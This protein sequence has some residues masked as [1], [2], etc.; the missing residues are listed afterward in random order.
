MATGRTLAALGVIAALVV[1]VLV[2]GTGD[3]RRIWCDV[4]NPTLAGEDGSTPR[5]RW[6]PGPNWT[7]SVPG[8]YEFHGWPWSEDAPNFSP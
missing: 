6:T 3:A 4:A 5:P 2:L 8:C 7:E 1:A